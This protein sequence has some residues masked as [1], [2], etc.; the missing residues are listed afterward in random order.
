MVSLSLWIHIKANS[1]IFYFELSVLTACQNYTLCNYLH[2]GRETFYFILKELKRLCSF[3][4]LF[5][6]K[7]ST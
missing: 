5:L 6:K 1:N 3:P 7:Y 2:A 4:K